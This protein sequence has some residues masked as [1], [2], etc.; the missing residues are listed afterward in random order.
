MCFTLIL[1][2]DCWQQSN[3]TVVA[4]SWSASWGMFLVL[5]SSLRFFSPF[6]PPQTVQFVQG[7]FVE[8]Y[9]PTI[10]DSYRKVKW[11]FL[12]RRC[13]RACAGLGLGW[14]R[15]PAG[16]LSSYITQAQSCFIPGCMS[17]DPLFHRLA[18]MSPALKTPK[19]TLKTCD[20]CACD[21]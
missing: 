19:H 11:F 18:E 9:D 6:L 3:F 4:F 10:E 16:S 20:I 15:V 14:S 8:K 1:T 2:I 21:N 17:S 5:F 7:I 12:C 13:P